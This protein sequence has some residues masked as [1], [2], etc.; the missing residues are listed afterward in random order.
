VRVN[1]YGSDARAVR[2]TSAK[3]MKKPFY[4]EARGGAE[5]K[6]G[7]GTIRGESVARRR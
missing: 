4:F 6:F 5:V 7:L 1:A 3:R 2:K